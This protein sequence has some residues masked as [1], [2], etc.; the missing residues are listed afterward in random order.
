MVYQ[1]LTLF[2]VTKFRLLYGPLV[3][4]L[5][6]KLCGLL[7]LSAFHYFNSNLV[8]VWMYNGIFGAIT[9]ILL[10]IAASVVNS[11]GLNNLSFYTMVAHKQRTK[12]VVKRT[13]IPLD[14]IRWVRQNKPLNHYWEKIRIPAFLIYFSP[15]KKKKSKNGGLFS[16]FLKSLFFL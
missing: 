14:R 7:I 15:K 12:L 13:R 1:G 16:W 8:I 4:P 3:F 10:E 2:S 11:L 5:P 6:I 9:L